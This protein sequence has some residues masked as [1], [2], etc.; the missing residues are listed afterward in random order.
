MP[1]Y[2]SRLP[3]KAILNLA[4]FF[5]EEVKHSEDLNDAIIAMGAIIYGLVRERFAIQPEIP[6]ANHLKSIF[7]DDLMTQLSLEL[8][9]TPY[10]N[11]GFD[12]QGKSLR[13]VDYSSISI[14]GKQFELQIVSEDYPIEF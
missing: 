9:S 1:A 8:S 3:C 10:F 13:R 2:Q 12:D 14:F 4:N 11:F 7:D 6:V 5:S